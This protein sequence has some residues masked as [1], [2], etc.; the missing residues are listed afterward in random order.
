MYLIAGRSEAHTFSPLPAIGSPAR[1][2]HHSKY[3]RKINIV[4]LPVN[5]PVT[6]FICQAMKSFEL[7]SRH[8]QR[9]L[10]YSLETIQ[11]AEKIVVNATDATRTRQYTSRHLRS[12]PSIKAAVKAAWTLGPTILCN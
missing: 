1:W 9:L 11:N 5:K 12:I 4:S 2:Q 10:S 7:Y 3:L 8:H 6:I